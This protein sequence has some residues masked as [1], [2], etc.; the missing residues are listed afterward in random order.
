VNPYERLVRAVGKSR[1]FA[2]VGPRIITRLDEYSHDRH[3]PDSTLGTHLE[4]VYL[5]TTGRVSGH[6]H[7]VPLLF[8][9]GD[10]GATVVAG[11]NWGRGQDPDWVHNLRADPHAVLERH[12]ESRAVMARPLEGSEFDRYWHRLNEIWP[13]YDA[14]RERSQREVVVF[15]LEPE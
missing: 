1:L 15:A 4:L 6:K 9:A 14:Y 10:N 3:L 13:A 2:W 11:T 5:T 12:G 8:V 7:A